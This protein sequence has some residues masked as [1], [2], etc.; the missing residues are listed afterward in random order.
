M[1]VSPGQNPACGGGVAA[2]CRYGQ[3]HGGEWAEEYAARKRRTVKYHVQEI[4]LTDC[5]A[6][7]APAAVLEFGCGVGRHLRI[8]SRLAGVEVYG[9]D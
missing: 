4:M 5:V 2:N 6:H 8:L 1:T 9:Y 3:E 7:H